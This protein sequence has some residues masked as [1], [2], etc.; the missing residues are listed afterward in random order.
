MRYQVR[1]TGYAQVLKA[2]DEWTDALQYIQ[3]RRL[4]IQS[5]LPY[6]YGIEHGHH[7]RGGLARAAGGAF[8]FRA[9]RLRVKALAANELAAAAHRGPAAIER[10]WDELGVEGV[11]VARAIVPVRSGALRD[12]IEAWLGRRRVA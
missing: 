2:L 5:Q 6:A 10:A 8:F 4:R 12:S 9:A 3:N 1:L 7:R 11:R